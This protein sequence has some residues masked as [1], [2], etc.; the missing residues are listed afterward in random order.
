MEKD[1]IKLEIPYEEIY[2]QLRMI[3]RDD[4]SEDYVSSIDHIL[5]LHEYGKE[6]GLIGYTFAVKY[7][8]RYIGIILVGEAIEW[9]TD[10]PE[11]KKEPFYRILNFVIDKDFRGKGIGGYVFEKAVEQ[12]YAAFGVRP[13]A[14]GCHK[15]NKAAEKFYLN[16]GFVKTEY[17]EDEDF[18]FLR[19]P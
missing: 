3:Q 12:V 2:P 9:K 17:M 16:H 13:L 4:I 10:P 1:K 8:D 18:Y 7:E 15:E 6:H 5:E 11:M 19:Y 14:L